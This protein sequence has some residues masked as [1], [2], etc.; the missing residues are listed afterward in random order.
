M[1]IRYRVVKQ[2]SGFDRTGTGKYAVK[3][4]TGETL[5][6]STLGPG[7][8]TRV[9]DSEKIA[10]VSAIYRRKMNFMP[11]SMFKNFLKDVSLSR[12]GETGSKEA[13]G[14]SEE[15]QRVTVI[16]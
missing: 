11:G 13:G 8:R 1:S 6:F 12:P 3:T 16:P 10:H 14:E 15:R 9:P 7:L 4:V 2:V 5:T